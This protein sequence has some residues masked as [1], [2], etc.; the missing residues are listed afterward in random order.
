[1]R[2]WGYWK[3]LESSIW[4]LAQTARGLKMQLEL[5]YSKSSRRRMRKELYSTRC[6]LGL[7]SFHHTPWGFPRIKSIFPWWKRQVAHPQCIKKFLHISLLSFAS[8]DTFAGRKKRSC[9][10][11]PCSTPWAAQTRLPACMGH[12]REQRASRRTMCHWSLLGHRILLHGQLRHTFLPRAVLHQ[13]K[14]LIHH[15][16][17]SHSGW[18]PQSCKT[19][20]IHC[21]CTCFQRQSLPESVHPRNVSTAG[22][23]KSF[24]VWDLAANRKCHH[25]F[26]PNLL[27]PASF[28]VVPA[29]SCSNTWRQDPT[30]ELL[31]W[32]LH[33]SC[34]LLWIS[35][36]F[37]LS[38]L[39]AQNIHDVF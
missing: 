4:L 23:K 35:Q 32:D 37:H 18:A 9:Q 8:S 6:A 27:W 21:N 33:P 13:A 1:M 10:G 30:Y 3:T 38:S 34:L 22:F 20:I 39:T 11:F 7:T 36:H 12:C 31:E 29:C 19:Q 16:V 2:L 5:A 26:I 14:T 28:Y 15:G 24:R 25:S 17:F